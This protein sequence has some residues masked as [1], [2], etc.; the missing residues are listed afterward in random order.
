MKN[1]LLILSFPLIFSSACTKKESSQK[2]S[3]KIQ[4][5]LIEQALS[6]QDSTLRRNTYKVLTALNNEQAAK[7]MVQYLKKEEQAF[8]IKMISDAAKKS[9]QYVKKIKQADGSSKPGKNHT[10]DAIGTLA[11]PMI[12][13]IVS[14]NRNINE[15]GAKEALAISAKKLLD[16]EI[17]DAEKRTLWKTMKKSLQGSNELKTFCQDHINQ[18]EAKVKGDCLTYLAKS[19]LNYVKNN[20]KDLKKIVSEHPSQLA[21][22]LFYGCPNNYQDLYVDLYKEFASDTNKANSLVSSLSRFGHTEIRG[23]MRRVKQYVK[24]KDTRVSIDNVVDSVR[25]RAKQGKCQQ[26]VAARQRQ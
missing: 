19:D 17:S 23:I 1:I 7:L 25:K 16:T 4:L 26:K 21:K 9:S 12:S 22:L 14:A 6:S 18:E 11:D 3:D 24:A 5:P 20:W 15:D 10:L 8:K 13:F 2:D